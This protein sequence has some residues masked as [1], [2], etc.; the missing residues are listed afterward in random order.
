MR[1]GEGR[2]LQNHFLSN[3]PILRKEAVFFS[4]G[5]KNRLPEGAGIGNCFA[6]L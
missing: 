1:R 3:I 2:P 5:L 4:L 6:H